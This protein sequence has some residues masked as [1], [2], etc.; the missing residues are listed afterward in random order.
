MKRE[1]EGKLR[2]KK[3]LL[4]DH[5]KRETR[6]FKDE[7]LTDEVSHLHHKFSEKLKS[8]ETLTGTKEKMT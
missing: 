8:V 1:E 5:C 3:S 7:G 2:K 6:R 4:K